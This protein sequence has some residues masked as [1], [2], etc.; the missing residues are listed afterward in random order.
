[1]KNPRQCLKFTLCSRICVKLLPQWKI[2]VRDCQSLHTIC[3]FVLISQTRRQS[4]CK[5]VRLLQN[6]VSTPSSPVALLSMLH[7]FPYPH[8]CHGYSFFW[9]GRVVSKALWSLVKT[10]LH[11]YLCC[12]TLIPSVWSS[13]DGDIKL[14]GIEDVPDKNLVR[15]CWTGWDGL[16]PLASGRCAVVQQYQRAPHYLQCTVTEARRQD[17]SFLLLQ[18]LK[19]TPKQWREPF[20]FEQNYD[21]RVSENRIILSLQN[22]R[23]LANFV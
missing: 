6:D 23:S 10:P 22:V 14:G 4:L 1:M 17:G 20:S 18:S 15:Q 5:R 11:T 7:T 16:T 19:L 13:F 3:V 9:Q 21:L 12:V 2:W 8:C